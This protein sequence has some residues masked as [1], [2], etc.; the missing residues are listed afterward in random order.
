MGASS[1]LIHTKSSNQNE[2]QNQ[3]IEEINEATF[4]LNRLV[5][6]L[7]DMARLESGRLIPNFKSCDIND[8]FNNILN[9]FEKKLKSHE[10]EI[11]ISK[12]FPF[13][14]IDF[15]LMEQAL[16]NILQNALNYTI[17]NSKIELQASFDKEYFYIIISDNGKG[18][19]EQNLEHIFGKFYRIENNKSGG[20][21]LGLSIAKGIV[22]IHKGI[23]SVSNKKTGGLKF[24]IKIPF[25]VK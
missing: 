25:E 12:G 17:S 8:L 18:I 16:K 9:D 20:T 3:L 24:I 10:I 13:I 1:Y 23:I 15:V 6:N 4:R 21:G 2:T 14:N 7:L 22:E 19:P 11:N 5:E